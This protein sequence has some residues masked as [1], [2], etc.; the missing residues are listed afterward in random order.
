MTALLERCSQLSV[1]DAVKLYFA[2]SISF[3]CQHYESIDE[4]EE[5]KSTTNQINNAN[6]LVVLS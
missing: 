1:C 2:L 3:A 4:K 6:D 5:E